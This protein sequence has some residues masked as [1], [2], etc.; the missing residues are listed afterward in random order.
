MRSFYSQIGSDDSVQ[1]PAS[2]MHVALQ[3][4]SGATNG[5]ARGGT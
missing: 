4:F 1:K 3:M 2:E 5:V